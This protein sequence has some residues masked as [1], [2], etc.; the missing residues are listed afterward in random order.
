MC[1]D[2]T[3]RVLEASR[4]ANVARS[5]HY[6]WLEEDPTYRAMFQAARIKAAQRLEAVRVAHYGL[7]KL[8]LY[9]G[10][11]ARIEGKLLYAHKS[12]SNRLMARLLKALDPDRFNR[13]REASH[14]VDLDNLTKGQKRDLMEWL[15]VQL[16]RAR[17]EAEATA[18]PTVEAT[19]V[20]E[21]AKQAVAKAKI[22]PPSPYRGD[23]WPY[24]V[25]K[26]RK[27]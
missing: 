14:G 24:K 15:R 9:K 22:I 8:V 7:P 11:P 20:T 12:Y 16:Q 26:K 27:R 25:E 21:P 1:Y 10:E 5:A 18:E 17:A 19:P 3:G 13:Q 4:W 6:Q 23:G 2:E